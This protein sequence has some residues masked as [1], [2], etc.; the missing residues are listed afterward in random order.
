M[1]PQIL[2]AVLAGF[3][4]AFTFSF[5]DFIVAFFVAGAQTTLPIYVFAS[6]RRGRDAG[7]QRHRDDRARRLRAAGGAR[8]M[9]AAP[10]KTVK[11]KV[12]IMI[13]KDR[14]AVVTGA[15]SG[16]GRAGAMIM[17]RE[18]ALVVI[19][20]RDRASGEATACDI[21]A[22]GGRA[23]AI[24]T[25]VADDAAVEQLIAGTLDRHGVS[26]SCTTMPA[27]RSAVR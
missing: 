21:R 12:D 27:S 22:A 17:A 3:L 9:A 11:L 16:I 18:G 15:G 1:L 26:T 23:E 2:P 25:D 13:L 20:D 6:I 10:A 5:D 7:N 24:A 8:P 19:A 14:I 4:L